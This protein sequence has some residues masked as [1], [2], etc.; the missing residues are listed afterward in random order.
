MGLGGDLFTLFTAPMGSA[1]YIIAKKN[2]YDGK[3][4]KDVGK[5]GK[6]IHP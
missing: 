4:L 6:K 2:S 5:L 1:A 3:V